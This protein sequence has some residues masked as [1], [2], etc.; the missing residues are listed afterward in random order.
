MR[1]VWRAELFP[2]FVP[3]GKAT[4][5]KTIDLKSDMPSVAEAMQRLE[6]AIASARRE[7][8][9]PLK[10]IHGYGSTGVGGDIRIAVQKRLRELCDAGEIR[11]C[12]FGEDWGKSDE[13]TWRLLQSRPELKDDPHLGRRNKGITVVLL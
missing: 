3:A 5:I 1:V 9:S 11:D 12:I 8:T 10:V 2:E 4:R 13:A 6:Q 7:N